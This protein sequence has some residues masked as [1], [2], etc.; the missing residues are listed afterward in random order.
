MSKLSQQFLP[1]LNTDKIYLDMLKTW[2]WIENTRPQ[3][4]TDFSNLFWIMCLRIHQLNCDDKY[5]LDVMI[6]FFFYAYMFQAW[7]R[8]WQLRKYISPRFSFSAVVK[9]MTKIRLQLAVPSSQIVL[10]D[11][12]F[13]FPFCPTPFYNEH[14]CIGQFAMLT[15]VHGL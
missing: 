13:D 12:S 3:W 1:Y 5:F 6:L 9:S 14:V 10:S 11:R 4:W 2:R 15:N 8:Q 7:L